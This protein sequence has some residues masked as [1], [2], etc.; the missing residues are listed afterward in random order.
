MDP[1]ASLYSALSADAALT[2]LLDTI[3]TE[4]G[5]VPAIFSGDVLPGSYEV[6]AMPC[7]LIRP[8]YANDNFETFDSTT[9]AFEHDVFVYALAAE[10]AETIDDAARA[11]KTAL[12]K[13]YLPAPSGERSPLCTV[14]GPLGAPTSRTEIAGRRLSARLS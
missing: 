13:Q 4:D 1:I 5:S 7:I 2:A 10:S 9:E 6:S 11:V 3:E 12:H 14:I 8:A